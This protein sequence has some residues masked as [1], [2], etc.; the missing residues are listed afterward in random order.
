[1][2]SLVD[3]YNIALIALGNDPVS[4]PNDLSTNARTI[5]ALLP[6]TRDRVLAAHP[7]NFALMREALASTGTA[8]A[9]D[10]A[11]AYTLPADPYC[12]RAWSVYQLEDDQWR[13]E[14]RE[15]LT[16]ALASTDA[17]RL[18][19]IARIEDPALFAPGFVH[20]L[21]HELA[22]DACMKVTDSRSL[23]ADILAECKLAWRSAK[24]QNAQER[25]RDPERESSFESARD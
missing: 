5:A 17:C 1:M 6:V 21:G 18:V 16:S 14:G 8:P 10:F 7:W 20:V 9:F 22:A 11:T 3:I 13:I 24:A 25:G 23:K 2:A 19:Y 12:L 4:D 15:L